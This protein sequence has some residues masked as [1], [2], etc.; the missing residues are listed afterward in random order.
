[1]NKIYLC[2]GVLLMWSAYCYPQ[3]DAE[4]KR[5]L[6]SL[7]KEDD[8][9]SML[10]LLGE[11]SSYLKVNL[12]IGNK[13]F[14]I[15]NNAL[16]A[17]DQNKRL[18]F[19][20]SIEYFN[21]SGFGISVAGYVINNNN[22][23]AF[24]QYA[25]TPSYDYV[26]GK[27]IEAGISFTKFFV[28]DKY[29]T[30][31]SPI[32]NDLYIYTNLKKTWLKPGIAFGYSGGTYNEINFTD[33][34]VFQQNRMIRIQFT[35]TVNTR[36]NAVS[37]IATVS[38]T[39]SEYGIIKS[40]DALS[41]TPQLLLNMGSSKYVVSHKTSSMLYRPYTKTTTTRIRNFQEKSVSPALKIESL[42]L[43]LDA[44]YRIGKLIFE[45]QLYLD[46]YLPST[47]EKRFS[48]VFCFNVGYVF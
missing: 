16:N 30:V 45:P 27:K 40:N 32:Q 21:K 6:D 48:Q 43:S 20:P 17:M 12:N 29:S 14:S 26:S 2:I 37:L 44:T 10:N 25:I 22:K 13:L 15:N 28:K 38:H 23:T 9:L 7:I 4:D 18:I 3:K 34:T 8:F 31:S 47:T 24:Y 35:D 39:F 36:I 46:Y 33:T 1:M 19:T 41:F 42:G 11:P 5:L